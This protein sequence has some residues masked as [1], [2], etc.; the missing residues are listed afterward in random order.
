MLLSI[1]RHSLLS[2]IRMVYDTVLHSGDD[3][4]HK[5]Y[6]KIRDGAVAAVLFIHGIVGTPNHFGEFV[7]LIPDSF[8]VYN[9]LL[10]GHGK[11]VRDFTKS[12]MKNWEEQVAAVV[13][14]LALTHERIYIVAHSLG[15][16]L[17]MEQ[18]VQNAKVCKLFL[19]AVPLRLSLKPKMLSNSLK[20]YLGRIR[21][22]D[23][24]ALAA[25]KCYGIQK[26]KNPFHYIGWIPRFL[27]L[28]AKM[29]Q[30]RETIQR[31]QTPCVVYQS[32]KDE[33]VS[34]KTVKYLRQNPYIVINELENAGHYYYAKEEFAFL[35]TE[36]QKM[37]N[38]DVQL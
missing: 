11:G 20:V 32:R 17:A 16:L 29:R 27:E 15:T 25:E 4:E 24:E 3:M 33:M 2:L 30:S 7:P 31:L 19:L 36:F 23:D 5:E 22:G 21:P 1:C 12:S 6:I 34:R 9:M 38:A 8:S 37:L 28:F 26:D 14:G 18:A 13:K 35:I 10:D